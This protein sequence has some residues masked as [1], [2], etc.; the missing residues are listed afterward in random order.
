MSLT[1]LFVYLSF[2]WSVAVVMAFAA[3]SRGAGSLSSYAAW[4]VVAGGPAMVA[5]LITRS[6]PTR[7][8]TQILQDA[9]DTPKRPVVAAARG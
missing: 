4:L 5:V 7:S 1:R 6:Q 9:E 8:V 2:T 3:W